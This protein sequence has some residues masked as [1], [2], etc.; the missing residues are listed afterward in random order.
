[1]LDIFAL[2]PFDMFTVTAVVEAVLP[3]RS[4]VEINPHLQTSLSRPLNGLIQIR[5]LSAHI[6]ITRQRLDRPV[7]NGDTDVVEACCCHVRKV[8]RCEEGGPVLFEFGFGGL[9]SELLRESV[10]VDSAGNIFEEG[11]GNPGCAK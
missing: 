8:S 1:M 4:T 11:G 6:G 7:S 5:E 10:F 3:T 2:L 9:L